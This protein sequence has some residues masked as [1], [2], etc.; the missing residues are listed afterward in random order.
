MS[1][2]TR[3]QIEKNIKQIDPLTHAKKLRKRALS[4]KVMMVNA[5]NDEVILKDR[6][7]ELAKA[8]GIENKIQWLKGYGHY[9][10]IALMPELMKKS[11]DFFSIDMPKDATIKKESTPTGAGKPTMA[12][13]TVLK[14]VSSFIDSP[15]GKGKAHFLNGT[16]EINPKNKDKAIRATFKFARGYGNKFILECNLPI[17]GNLSIGENQ[18]PWMKSKNNK[19]FLG[20]KD[21]VENGNP[22]IYVSPNHLLSIQMGSG[23]LATAMMMPEMADKYVI[24]KEEKID[25]KKVLDVTIKRKFGGKVKITFKEDNQTPDNATFNIKGIS[26]KI[27]FK[28]FFTNTP[29]PD[30]LFEPEGVKETEMVSERDIYGIWGETFNFITEKHLR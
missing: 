21:Q 29:V 11:V 12:F 23:L 9:T 18:F 30:S 14:K 17:V 13:L 16:I 7:L 19:V 15:P 25:N 2:K 6:T 3:K 10:T 5:G 20:K 28:Q 27:T 24:I 4:G 26:G 1:D 22:V 8:L